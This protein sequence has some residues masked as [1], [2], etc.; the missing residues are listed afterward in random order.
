MKFADS[1]SISKNVSIEEYREFS[2]GMYTF[3]N[4]RSLLNQFFRTK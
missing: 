2:G 4:K 1:F 3:P